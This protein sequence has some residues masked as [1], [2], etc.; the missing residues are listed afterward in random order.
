MGLVLC[1]YRSRF[2]PE[3]IARIN[4]CGKLCFN[5]TMLDE[6]KMRDSKYLR[7]FFDKEN[8]I[9][10]IE[11]SGQRLDGSAKFP[12]DKSTSIRGVFAY[13]SVDY[14]N[15]IGEYRAIKENC[16]SLIKIYLKNKIEEE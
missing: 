14:K 13:F 3:I 16:D 8:Q 4:K 15:Y 12:K 9:L 7:F 11:L 1:K 10:A 5:K 2:N 6:Y